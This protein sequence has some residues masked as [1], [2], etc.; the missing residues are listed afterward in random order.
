MELTITPHNGTVSS[1]GEMIPLGIHKPLEGCEG[2]RYILRPLKN[3]L[4]PAGLII[5]IQRGEQTVQQATVPFLGQ[6]KLTLDLRPDRPIYP[7]GEV[8]KK[9]Q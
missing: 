7:F 3:G 8:N 9:V 5:E 1:G 6:D 2:C 4:I